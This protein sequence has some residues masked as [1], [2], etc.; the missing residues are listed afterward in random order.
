MKQTKVSLLRFNIDDVEVIEKTRKYQGFFA[1]DEYKFR[2]KLYRGGFSKVLT[3]EV[4]ERGD[5]VAILPYDPATD[6]IVLIEQFR[7]GA[8]RSEHGP[9]QLELIAGM[10]GTNEQPIEVAI[11]E[12]KEEANLVILPNNVTKIMNY[13]SSSGGMS[14][15]IHL[16]CASVDSSNLSG[17]YGLEEEGEDI[18]VHVVARKQALAL[19]ESGKITNAATIIALQWLQL[20]I[21][22]LK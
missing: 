10:F 6:S 21:D 11:R 13:L 17:V 14:E 15:C 2:H 9:W 4:F 7:P 19:L 1:L 3:R 22:K 18:L 8:L 16:Y 12:A 20:N 5:A